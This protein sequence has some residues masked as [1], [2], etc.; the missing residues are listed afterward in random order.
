M[1]L[2]RRVTL[3][4]LCEDLDSDWAN[5]HQ[6]REFARLWRLA[7][8]D[9]SNGELARIIKSL[10][11]TVM[12]DHP[13]VTSFR[14]AFEDDA[15][16]VRRES[17][18]G[19]SNPHFWK[20]KSNR[21]RGAATEA[22]DAVGE[23]EVWLC[24]G[25]LRAQ[26]DNRDF[27]N[28]FCSHIKAHGALK[29]LPT[30]ADRRYQD[31]EAK[32]ARRE[33]WRAQIQLSTLICLNKALKTR[34]DNSLHV[35]APKPDSEDAP[36]LHATFQV[37]RVDDAVESITELVV[38]IHINDLKHMNLATLA[39]NY[40]LNAIEPNVEAWSLLPGAGTDTIWA[41]DVTPQIGELA[42]TASESNELPASSRGKWAP[43]ASAHYSRKNYLVEAH[44]KGDPV[45][46]LCGTWFVPTDNP[47][48]H[49]IC[50]ICKE[51]YQAL[52]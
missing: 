11:P 17:I 32:N 45:R 7:Q 40:V 44:V 48:N 50:P 19:L 20:Q 37:E 39:K 24:A 13:L 23:G 4:C 31:V 33:A 5:S 16:T 18:S 2:I 21:W 43:A 14:S 25:G 42:A 9:A 46:G 36:L 30:A 6:R 41:T 34:E 27:Y 51:R 26:G 28:Q 35:P 12:I 1:G 10:P 29:F 22:I 38:Q 3:R 15:K 47:D 8:G 52:P 49:P